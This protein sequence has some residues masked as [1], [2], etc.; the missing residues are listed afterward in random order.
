MPEFYEAVID[1]TNV[2]FEDFDKIKDE[3]LTNIK[4]EKYCFIFDNKKFGFIE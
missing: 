4:N 3:I 2:S 1:Y